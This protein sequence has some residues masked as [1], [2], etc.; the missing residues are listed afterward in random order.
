M[1]LHPFSQPLHWG[2]LSELTFSPSDEVWRNRSTSRV[3]S[4]N[5]AVK[6]M[7]VSPTYMLSMWL[8]I[9]Y[10]TRRNRS[11][12][13]VQIARLVR[14]VVSRQMTKVECTQ[15]HVWALKATFHRPLSVITNLKWKDELIKTIARVVEFCLQ[16]SQKSGT[17]L[18]ASQF[19]GEGRPLEPK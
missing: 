16:W 4:V 7:I 11:E 10:Q 2:V 18:R 12:K 9:S 6:L 17:G 3:G 1:H 15:T 13:R 5:S 19:F 14:K 8:A